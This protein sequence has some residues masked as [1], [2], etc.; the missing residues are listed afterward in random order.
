MSSRQ[1]LVAAAQRQ[2][3]S[4]TERRHGATVVDPLLA[5][6]IRGVQ[7]WSLFAGDTFVLLPAVVG[8]LQWPRR[9]T[10]FCLFQHVLRGLG[11][12]GL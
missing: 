12:W 3:Q 6:C 11:R 10:R 8:L 7:C 5:R 1:Q 4:Q 9:S 2:S